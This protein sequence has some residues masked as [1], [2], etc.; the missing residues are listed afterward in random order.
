[1]VLLSTEHLT[2]L[3]DGGHARLP[4][5]Q[6]MQGTRLHRSQPN[7]RTRP[8][9]SIPAIRQPSPSTFPRRAATPTSY[10]SRPI[11]PLYVPLYVP[12]GKS[13][14]SID[15]LL[16][17]QRASAPS[18][19]GAAK[20]VAAGLHPDEVGITRPLRR[21]CGVPPAIRAHVFSE[22]EARLEKRLL[23]R[24]DNLCDRL[25]LR[26]VTPAQR[27]Q[28]EK[29][30]SDR[31]LRD[32]L[33]GHS[34]VPLAVEIPDRQKEALRV[35]TFPCN[36]IQSHQ[37]PHQPPGQINANSA[38]YTKQNQCNPTEPNLSSYTPILS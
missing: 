28:A 8:A 9:S 17:L 13:L 20:S 18:M 15:S 16:R 2:E 24:V 35:R 12:P 10:G 29:V 33:E 7:L 11:S 5:P 34:M 14:R 1:M 30:W 23:P 3:L 22:L 37:I 19:I 36:Q 31:C 4:R 6:S 32:W 26:K 38:S 27:E 25:P 21:R